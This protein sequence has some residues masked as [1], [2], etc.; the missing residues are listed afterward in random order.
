MGKMPK[1]IEDRLTLLLA[2]WIDAYR[3]EGFPEP[4]RLAWSAA[5]KSALARAWFSTPRNP[6]PSRPCHTVPG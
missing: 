3:P 5:M 1:L 4:S 6:N 2:D